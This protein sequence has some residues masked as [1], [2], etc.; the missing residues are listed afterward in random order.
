MV[1]RAVA[2][3]LSFHVVAAP[4]KMLI[5]APTNHSVLQKGYEIL[6]NMNKASNPDRTPGSPIRVGFPAPWVSL[7]PG[8]QHTLAA[9]LILKNKFQALISTDSRGAPI[10]LGATSWL[11]S[12]DFRIYR[13]TIDTTRTFSD[14]SP[15]SA[16]DYKTSWEVAAR[17]NPLSANSSLL[18][19]LY[20]IEGFESFETEGTISGI[21][22][23]SDDN[24]EIRFKSPF[25]MALEFLQGISMAA[26]KESN[27]ILI[28]TGL[29]EFEELDHQHVILHPRQDLGRAHLAT[30]DVRVVATDDIIGEIN[31]GSL[32]V[33]FYLSGDNPQITNISSDQVKI[34]VGQESINLGLF[35]NHNSQSIFS[36]KENRQAL[37]FL[38]EQELSIDRT[39]LPDATYFTYDMQFYLPIQPGRLD[40]STV[41]ALVS[42]GDTHVETFLQ[43]TKRTPIF[44]QM[45]SKGGLGERLLALLKRTGVVLDD[46]SGIISPREFLKIVYAED[47]PDILVAGFG[48]DT[49]DPDGLYHILGR[50]GAIRSPYVYSPVVGDM[51]EEGR[52]L[53]SSQELDPFY[54]TVSRVLLE[55]VPI[56][57]LGFAKALL[58]YRSDRLEID[59]KAFEQNKGEMHFLKVKR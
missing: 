32:D 43:A 9:D 55:E 40:A 25:R 1:T 14:G 13:F 18:D 49:G 20:K 46:R 56:V 45:Q 50:N 54:K 47:G 11:I 17:L 28:G 16:T 22:V 34:L 6:I 2:I 39:L 10:P 38:L 57:H 58:A 42:N 5:V 37:Q 8:L 53:L 36:K 29:Y 33:A 41:K 44:V 59:S 27:G 30:L 15:L 4:A 3:G 23:L 19:T 12:D 48:V 7:H 21:R 31:S 24:L 52:K 51:L 26:F 35:L